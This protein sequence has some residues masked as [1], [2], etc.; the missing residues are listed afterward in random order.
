MVNLTAIAGELKK[1]QVEKET[2]IS[3]LVAFLFQQAVEQ[4]ASDIYLEPLDAVISIR[5][6][7]DGMLHDVAELPLELQEKLVS[8]IKVLANLIVYRRDIPQDGHI[9]RGFREDGVDLRVTTFP[10]IHGEKVLIRIFNS[11]QVLFNLGELG[12]SPDTEEE[13]RKLIFRPQGTI[14]LTGPS[15]SGKTTTIY[16]A[17]KEIAREKRDIANIVTIEDPVEYN[18]KTISQT[19][20]NLSAGLTFA[21]S[22]RSILR[23]DPE[24]IML[25][26]I[27]DVETAA[28]AIQA[29]LTGHLVISTIHSGTATGVFARLIAMEIEPFLIAS[30]LS[31]VLAQ[32]LVRVICPKCKESYQP[33]RALIGALGL[34]KISSPTF[35]KGRGCPECSRTGYRGRI[36][37]T[38]LLTV[39]EKFREAIL[40]KSSTTAL[41][42]VAEEIGMR[43]LREDGLRKVEQGITTLEELQRVIVSEEGMDIEDKQE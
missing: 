42:K 28:I 11:S 29:G 38:E 19:Q 22:L 25:G 27:R 24:V 18:L 12:F 34:K 14:L 8:R 36:A 5:Y 17:L 31:G 33:S 2:Q 43:S 40:G 30:S 41:D 9:T 7:I 39:N 26:E 15:S 1:M 37:I 13:L 6:R 21:R 16:A 3:D 23:Q 32:R 20:V 35:F 10:T 4:R